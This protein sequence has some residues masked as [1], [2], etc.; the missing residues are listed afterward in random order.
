MNAAIALAL[1]MLA[2]AGAA[3]AASPYDIIPFALTAE[4]QRQVASGVVIAKIVPLDATAQSGVAIGTIGAP[5]GEVIEGIEDVTQH[6]KYFPRLLEARVVSGS[7]NL[8]VV[9]QKIDVPLPFHDRYYDITVTSSRVATPRDVFASSWTYVKG[10]G[11]MTNTTGGWTL[12][13][14][15]ANTTLAYYHVHAD[16]GTWLPQRLLNMATRSALPDVIKGMRRYCRDH[17]GGR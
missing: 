17:P 8:H 3:I 1:S 12:T 11:N 13:P 5:I 9:H 15:D 2:V 7:G 10:S 16:I 14:I 6:T 4:E